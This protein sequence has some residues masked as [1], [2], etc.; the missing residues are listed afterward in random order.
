MARDDDLELMRN[1]L[2]LACALLANAK[3]DEDSFKRIRAT[4]REIL[5]DIINTVH[6]WAKQSLQRAELNEADALADLYRRVYGD[7]NSPEFRER[8]RLE[9]E[10]RA[11]EKSKPIP[12]S[13]EA[14]LDRKLAERDALLRKRG[15][16]T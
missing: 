8:L 4:A 3:I 13:Q 10:M 1:N 2:T 14:L 5:N 16:Q 6:P 15:S 11:A 9:E 12:E 7:P